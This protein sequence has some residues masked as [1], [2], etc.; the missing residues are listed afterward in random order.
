MINKERLNNLSNEIW[1]G[2]IKLRGKFKAKD[3]PSVILPMIMIRRIECVLE[4]KREAFKAELLQKTPDIS[5]ADLKKRI[6]LLETT[7]LAFYNQSDWT[8]TKIL[9]DSSSQV[10]ANFREYINSYSPNIDEI[11]EKFDY[12]NTITQ[13]VK[14]KRLASIIE[15]AADEDFSPER[16]SNIEMGYVYEELLQKFSQDDAKD[17]GEHFTPR[18]IIRVMV[19]LMDILKFPNNYLW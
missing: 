12:R 8:L 11:I 2:A 6:K 14:A 16:L 15:L 17:T 13:I 9:E 4:T 3:Y 5:D 18:E 1:K 19:E 10:E 7:K